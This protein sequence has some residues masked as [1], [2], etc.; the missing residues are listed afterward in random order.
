MFERDCRALSCEIERRRV[1]GGF[2]PGAW[3]G[4]Q[5]LLLATGRSLLVVRPWGERAGCKWLASAR[6][7]ERW[8]SVSPDV[9][10]RARDIADLPRGERRGAAGRAAGRPRR[11]RHREDTRQL[12]L[13]LGEGEGEGEAWRTQRE[14]QEARHCFF[15]SIPHRPLA[16][17]SRVAASYQWHVLQLLNAG[18]EG[19]ADLFES[20]PALAVMLVLTPAVA[21]RA[22]LPDVR[23]LATWRQRRL[24]EELGFPGS[25]Q[26]LRVLRKVPPG[27][28]DLRGALALQRLCADPSVLA[29]LSH[30]PLVSRALL[31][32]ARTPE[33]F[34]AIER[35]VQEALLIPDCARSRRLAN[36]LEE[37][38]VAVDQAR[39]AGYALPARLRSA[40]HV[41]RVRQE[42]RGLRGDLLGASAFDGLPPPPLPGIPGTIEPLRCIGD[43][44]REGR[45]VRNCVRSYRARALSGR[46]AI[47]RVLTPERA[48][49]SIVPGPRGWRVS[50]LKARGNADPRPETK[51]V[52]Q[53]WLKR[54]APRGAKPR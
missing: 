21:P 10:L 50:E 7:G 29:R 30:L 51:R 15:E 49:L 11:P 14:R 52:V 16:I 1:N 6:S 18:G 23:E 33:R 4:D 26:T 20:T 43:L 47:Y 53:D 13:P 24:L 27:D 25:R 2:E 40:D 39:R 44:D 48:T 28:L 8:R 45:E 32:V 46:V 38:L 19:A 9:D 5:H 22:S 42:L 35:E 12:L 41:R 31:R 34:L 37:I 17:A 36:R 54:W 3:F